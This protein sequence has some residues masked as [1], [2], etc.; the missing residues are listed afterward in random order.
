V[1]PEEKRYPGF[2]EPDIASIL[3]VS[4]A[5][6]AKSSASSFSSVLFKT[7]GINVS[8]IYVKEI[9]GSPGPPPAAKAN[10]MMS[11]TNKTRATDKDLF[12]ALLHENLLLVLL[13]FLIIIA[14]AVFHFNHMHLRGS[15]P[16]IVMD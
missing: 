1:Y 12:T 10:P 9:R 13:R 11:I 2:I 4:S 3:C 15:T 8:L 14:C 16:I 5:S 6:R 7:E